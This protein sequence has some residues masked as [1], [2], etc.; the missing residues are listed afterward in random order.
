MALS[1]SSPGESAAS[2][3]RSDKDCKISASAISLL[4]RVVSGE[5]L[6][7][8]FDLGTTSLGPEARIVKMAA[9]VEKQ[10]SHNMS[11]LQTM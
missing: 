3:G 7:V 9:S 10:V 11:Y 2:T 8:F 6:L 5:K 1:R 4:C